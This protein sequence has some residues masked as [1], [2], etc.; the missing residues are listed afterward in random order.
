MHFHTL[1]EKHVKERWIEQGIWNNRW[2]R[3]VTWNGRPGGKWKHEEPL[4]PE[5]ESETDSEAE[6]EAPISRL[7]PPGAEAKPRRPKSDEELRR[8]AE[9]R[10]I[11]ERERE[12]SRPF[13]QFVYQV[14]KET[15]WIQ[16]VINVP[17]MGPSSSD[18]NVQAAPQALARSGWPHNDSAVQTNIP[19]PPD[20]NTMAYERVKNTWMK[21]GIWNK[22]WGVLPGMSWKHEQPLE[23]MLREEMGDDAA[24]VLAGGLQG[25]SHGTGEASP[26]SIFGSPLPAESNHEASGRLNTS[27]QEPPASPQGPPPAIDTIGLPNG[28]VNHSSAASNLQRR[29]VEF[30]DTPR[31]PLRRTR[32]RDEIELFVKGGLPPQVERNALGSV[33][34]SKVSKARKMSGP[35][36]RRRPKASEFLSDAQQALSRLD[37]PAALPRAAPVPL[38]RSRRLQEAERKPAADPI[39]IAA[40]GSY[41][42]GSQSRLRRTRAGPKSA[43]SA[44]PHGIS[45]SRPSIARRRGR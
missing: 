23:E 5:F 4:E 25:D 45:R 31:S 10:P 39:G 41:G 30:R 19:D 26:R 29:H 32:R 11:R 33:H 21:R 42:G 12:A 16:D 37:I 7:S 20:I 6:V 40:T 14:S 34:P 2:N 43:E 27:Q 22:K 9:R 28:D 8:V 18:L 17:K 38:R 13:P 15:E 3:P 35:G 24:L 1:A 36:S 44:K